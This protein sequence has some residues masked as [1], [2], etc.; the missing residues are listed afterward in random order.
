MK[1]YYKSKDYLNL[2]K[3]KLAPPNY[4]FGIVWPILYLLLAIS[5]YLIFQK[6]KFKLNKPIIIFLIHLFFNLIWTYLFINFKDKKIALVDLLLILILIIYCY[7]EF[8][9]INK[10]AGYLL[11]PYIVWLCFALYL[12]LFIVINN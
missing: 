10:I 1:N 3:S 4:V 6:S 9:K 5:F 2:K 7:F 12:N 8:I 11:L